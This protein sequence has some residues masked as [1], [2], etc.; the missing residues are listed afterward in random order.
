MK[1]KS[2]VVLVILLMLSLLSGCAKY[3]ADDFIG[4]T[5]AKNMAQYRPFDRVQF[6]ISNF[7]K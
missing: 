6:T 4:K 2:A 5:T 7:G 3:K 1:K